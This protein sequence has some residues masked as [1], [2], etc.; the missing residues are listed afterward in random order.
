MASLVQPTADIAEIAVA[1]RNG[2][3]GSATSVGGRRP[4]SAWAASARPSAR[5]TSDVVQGIVLC[6]GE[7]A[8]EDPRARA[9]SRGSTPASAG[10]VVPALIDRTLHTVRRNGEASACPHVLVAFLNANARS[11]LV[12]AAVVPLAPRRSCCSTSADPREPHLDGGD[13]LL[14]HRGLGCRRRREPPPHPRGAR[15]QDRSLGRDR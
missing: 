6:G 12:V 5:A 15:R 2:T 7:N 9:P 14:D 4:A 1:T 3:P 11:A 13:R 10:V 8:L